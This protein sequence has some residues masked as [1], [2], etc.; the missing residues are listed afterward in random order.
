MKIMLKN[1]KNPADAH[2][3]VRTGLRT[4][5][6]LY[7][8]KMVSTWLKMVQDGSKMVNLVPRWPRWPK[9]TW[10]WPKMTSSWL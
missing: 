2:T 8:L 9:L 5:L 1:S 10:R 7:W 4:T 3:E 6:N